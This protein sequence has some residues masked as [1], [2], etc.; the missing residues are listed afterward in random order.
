MMG[1]KTSNFSDQTAASEDE[2]PSVNPVVKVPG[3]NDATKRSKEELTWQTLRRSTM[4]FIRKSS[5]EEGL[6]MR[7]S[8]GNNNNN[9]RK[10]T[11][12]NPL[13]SIWTSSRKTLGVTLDAN[14]PCIVELR[15]AKNLPVMGNADDDGTN[16]FVT[17]KVY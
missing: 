17:M 13:K 10:S 16:P 7:E 3:S 12:N 14:Q 9:H 4:E 1:T 8:I 11:S 2:T 5:V 6:D 15:C